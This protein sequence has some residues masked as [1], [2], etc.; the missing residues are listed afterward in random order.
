MPTA[1]YL[2][3]V[4]HSS[5]DEWVARQIA[6]LI[7]QQGADTF[8]AEKHIEGG[9]QFPDSIRTSLQRCDEL[10]VL[11]S[12]YSIDRHWVQNE[13]G[14]AWVLEKRIVPVVDNVSLDQM[15]DILVRRQAIELNDLDAY[16]DQ[17]ETRIKQAGK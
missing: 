6:H 3:F 2:V 13:I 1:P 14:A 12:P 7:E 17:L 8:L 4:S 10:L 11:I 5:R 16:L 15:P 9:D